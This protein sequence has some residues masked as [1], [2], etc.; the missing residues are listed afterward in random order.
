[1][2]YMYNLFILFFI[3]TTFFLSS[4]SFCF[5]WLITTVPTYYYKYLWFCTPLLVVVM[6]VCGS[7]H[8]T[9]IRFFKRKPTREQE[10]KEQRTTK[11]KNITTFKQQTFIYLKDEISVPCILHLG[12]CHHDVC[13]PLVDEP[14]GRDLETERGDGLRDCRRSWLGNKHGKHQQ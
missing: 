14:N 11:T 10:T 9:E 8:E 2:Y 1:M 12:R 4:S 7:M 6:T 5:F 3:I 13:C